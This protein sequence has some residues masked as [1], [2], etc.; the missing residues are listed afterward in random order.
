MRE[1]RRAAPTDLSAVFGATCPPPP[2][3]WGSLLRYAPS[4]SRLSAELT[5]NNVNFMNFK[6]FVRPFQAAES[7]GWKRRGEEKRR[8]IISQFLTLILISR[9]RMSSVF[10]GPERQIAFFGRPVTVSHSAYD[11]QPCR[12]EKCH[13]AGTGSFC[14]IRTFW[15]TSCSVFI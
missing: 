13:H 3:R 10:R 2:H 12:V 8:S 11:L 5:Q 1:L 14:P 4:R 6:C 15:V 7:L 9:R